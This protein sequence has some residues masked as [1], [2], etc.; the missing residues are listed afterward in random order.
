RDLSP[1]NKPIKGWV[2]V[3][4]PELLGALGSSPKVDEPPP[5]YPQFI[6]PA[7]AISA[8]GRSQTASR[9]GNP[10]Q[11]LVSVVDSKRHSKGGRRPAPY[12]SSLMAA[13]VHIHKTQVPLDSKVVGT[14][15]KITH[16]ARSYMSQHNVKGVPTSRSALE[17]AI[18]KLI[19]EA[20]K[21]ADLD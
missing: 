20:M 13:L 1:R 9:P 15:A 5:H 7:P 8:E 14:L 17:D 18:K 11:V 4:E 12:R 2:L 19:P 10:L 21:K 3:S 6:N 16:L